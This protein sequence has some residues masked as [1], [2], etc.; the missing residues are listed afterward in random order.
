MKLHVDVNTAL[1]TV[2][3]YGVGYVEINRQRHSGAV[4]VR[5]QGEV[6]AWA[7]ASFDA[8]AAAD[9]ESLLEQRPEL[10]VLGTGDRQRFPHP[11][12]TAALTA[13]RIGVEAMDTR[14]ACRRYNILMSEGRKVVAALLPL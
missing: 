9:F 10:V 8:L 12:L 3:A 14:A 4:L 6:L 5:P 1:N 7:P 13:V 2:T 11:R